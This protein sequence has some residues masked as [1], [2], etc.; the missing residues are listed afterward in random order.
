MRRSAL[1]RTS[2]RMREERRRRDIAYANGEIPSSPPLRSYEVTHA[3]GSTRIVEAESAAQ[4][5]GIA[6]ERALLQGHTG[7]SARVVKAAECKEPA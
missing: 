6:R 5:L 2:D 3:D 7:Q 4:A 1:A